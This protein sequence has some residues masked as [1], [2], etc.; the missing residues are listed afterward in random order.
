[1]NFRKGAEGRC[2]SAWTYMSEN[3]TKRKQQALET[4]KRILTCALD[5]FETKGFEDVTIQDIAD[6]AQTSV[7]SIYRYFKNKEEMAAQNAE[8]LD[9][10]YVNFYEQLSTMQNT[11]ICPPWTSLPAFISSS[12]KPFPATAT[13]GASISTTSGISRRN[14]P[15][16]W[17][18]R[19]LPDLSFP[20]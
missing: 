9:D 1:M 7:G 19:S 15:D 3:L 10:L 11:G 18:P 14:P 20:V 17:K 6:A 16:G 2:A 8:P 13:C 4:R 5:L 12:R